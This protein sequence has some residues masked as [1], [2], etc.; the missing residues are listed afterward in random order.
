MSMRSYVP[1]AKCAL[2]FERPRNTM[3]VCPR[4]LAG[5]ANAKK[6]RTMQRLAFQ[7]NGYYGTPI[8]ATMTRF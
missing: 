6:P 8:N 2:R 5:V 7:A 4:K 3:L 1:Q